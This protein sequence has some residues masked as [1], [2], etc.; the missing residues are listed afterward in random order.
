[1]KKLA[2]AFS[3]GSDQPK[4]CIPRST[5]LL[6]V[7]DSNFRF[8]GGGERDPSLASLFFWPK[9]FGML[10][11]DSKSSLDYQIV[12]DCSTHPRLRIRGGQGNRQHS[13]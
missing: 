13:G 9:A 5:T 2:T 8:V 12:L 3:R 11:L 1:M 4:S 6:V 7:V 10:S